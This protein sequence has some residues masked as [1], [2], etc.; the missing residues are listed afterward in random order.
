MKQRTKT[1]NETRT[2]KPYIHKVPPDPATPT[3][4][5]IKRKKY[6]NKAYL[7]ELFTRTKRNKQLKH[8]STY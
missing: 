5:Y 2:D 4:A 8:S 1:I 3:S 6:T 7:K